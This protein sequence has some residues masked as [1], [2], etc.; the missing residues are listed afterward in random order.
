MILPRE[1]R[2][3]DGAVDVVAVT[4]TV[5]IVIGWFAMNTLVTELAG[6]HQRFHFYNMWSV[7][8]NP[9]RLLTGLS[10]GD[11][12]RG[13]AF[14]VVCIAAALSV[15]VP[16]RLKQRSAWLAYLIPLA[17]MILCGTLLYAKTS[18][19]YISDS[20]THGAIGS[21]LVAFANR[22][23]NRM[24]ESVAEHISIGLGAYVSLLAS[25]VLAARGIVR[26]RSQP[27]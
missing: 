10:D 11:T 25:A 19:D 5:V 2:S 14:G 6:I 9:A 23:A 1:S 16:Y 24:S 3:T 26:Y 22:V 20:G 27:S 18:G 15:L 8:Q 21:A 13:F 7:L 17:L 4:A 12:A